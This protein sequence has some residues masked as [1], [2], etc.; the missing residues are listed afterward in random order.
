LAGHVGGVC[1]RQLV[2][3]KLEV[4]LTRKTRLTKTP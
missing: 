2:L 3:G 4:Q 1:D